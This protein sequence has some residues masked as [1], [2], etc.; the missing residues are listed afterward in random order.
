MCSRGDYEGF[1]NSSSQSSI[2]LGLVERKYKDDYSL[3]KSKLRFNLLKGRDLKHVVKGYPIY[4]R[5]DLPYGGVQK[6]LEFRIHL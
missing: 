1:E 4:L 6:L 3:V 2:S 5:G